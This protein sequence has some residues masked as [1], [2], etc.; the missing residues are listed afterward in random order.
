M[1]MNLTDDNLTD[2]LRS[3]L[4]REREVVE[5]RVTGLSLDEIAARLTLSPSACRLILARALRQVRRRLKRRARREKANNRI[6][7][8][9]FFDRLN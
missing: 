4:P 1:V 2:A 7:E 9:R 5:M 3:L 8:A 6:E